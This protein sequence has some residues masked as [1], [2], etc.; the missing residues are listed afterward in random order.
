MTPLMVPIMPFWKGLMP[1]LF[2]VLDLK[3]ILLMKCRQRSSTSIWSAVQ[4]PRAHFILSSF[5]TSVEVINLKAKKSRIAIMENEVKIYPTLF[6]TIRHCRTL[7]N[8]IEHYW[9]LPNATEHYWKLSNTTKHCLTLWNTMEH[10]G[11]LS[12]TFE[13]IKHYPTLLNTTEHYPT[14][15]NTV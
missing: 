7:S 14:L 11:T 1:K 15:S 4:T 10:Y 12:N 3:L 9:T 8:I 5:S 2:W 13:N 6:N